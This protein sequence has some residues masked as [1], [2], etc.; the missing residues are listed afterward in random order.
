MK[1]LFVS[2][3][4]LGAP[5][6]TAWAKDYIYVV[7]DAKSN[8]Q[9]FDLQNWIQQAVVDP[10]KLPTVY[11]SSQS[12]S[13]LE[14]I[15]LPSSDDRIVGLV[16]YAK[17]LK[18]EEIPGE[19]LN[20]K[21]EKLAQFLGAQ[22]PLDQLAES[23][24]VDLCMSYSGRSRKTEDSFQTSFTRSLGAYLS[25]KKSPVQK[26]F[27]LGFLF[28]TNVSRRDPG[29]F[30]GQFKLFQNLP[31]LQLFLNLRQFSPRIEVKNL[32]KVPLYLAGIFGLASAFFYFN[33]GLVWGGLAAVKAAQSLLLYYF[34]RF[35]GNTATQFSVLEEWTPEEGLWRKMGSMGELFKTMSEDC[36]TW[37]YQRQ[38]QPFNSELIVIK[39]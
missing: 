18:F 7:G 26:L 3:L 1:F 36:T 2:F 29:Q 34:N 31:V 16:I 15:Q 4:L 35:V 28:Y 5:I 6:H 37:V 38:E 21:S 9:Q 19:D 11:Y 20:L 12:L 33:D 14:K 30:T 22:L 24:F 23:F 13:N 39:E 10:N 8:P 32:N 25:E 27:T 17:N